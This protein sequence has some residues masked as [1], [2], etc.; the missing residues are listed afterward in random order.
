MVDGLARITGKLQPFVEG[1]DLFA[2]IHFIRHIPLHLRL[3]HDTARNLHALDTGVTVGGRVQEV[4][5]DGRAIERL[6]RFNM[7]AA[8]SFGSE[9][10]NAYRHAWLFIDDR[11]STRLTSSH[12]SE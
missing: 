7:D 5:P 9:L 4:R 10:G 8:P 12:Y 2:R 11:T 6:G 3:A 1:M